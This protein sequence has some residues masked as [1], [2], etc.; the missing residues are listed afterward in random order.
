VD[1]YATKRE[2]ETGTKP[3]FVLAIA[4]QVVLAIAAPGGADHSAMVG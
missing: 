1:A 2:G 3:R 4:A